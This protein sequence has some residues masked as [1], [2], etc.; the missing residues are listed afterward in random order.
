[1]KDREKR[2]LVTGA[3]LQQ[4]G[5]VTA[6]DL[7]EASGLAVRVLRPVLR[8]LVAERL[9][10][11]LPPAEGGRAPLY[12]WGARHAE[13]DRV[14]AVQ[15]RVDLRAE[16]EA[17]RPE[18]G[19]EPDVENASA[20]AYHRYIIEQYVPPADKRYLVFFQCSVRRPFWS[21][22][23]HGSM[24]RAVSVATGFDPA[25]QFDR[26][27]VHVVVVASAVGPVPYDVQDVY[28]ANVGGIGV[29]Q[30]GEERYG[31]VRPLLAQRL[32]EYLAVHGGRYEYF[33]SFTSGRY[34]EVLGDA[35]RLSGVRFRVLPEA[36]GQVLVRMGRH[37]PRT[38]WQKYWIQLCLEIMSWLPPA[39]RAEAE[40]RM[41]KLEVEYTSGGG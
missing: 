15:A 29:V 8:E 31:R 13:V 39:Q 4:D 11:E 10:A 22:P 18:G 19:E 17:A 27:P 16:A 28:P 5:P 35:Q 38:Y 24:R 3:L 34:A 37:R 36:D 6:A 30:Y 21:S 12:V 20:R 33:S 40:A 26:C 25:R 23:S 9:V 32:A 1:M 41:R 14:R 7:A 2:Y